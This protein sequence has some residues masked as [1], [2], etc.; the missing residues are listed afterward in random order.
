MS[1]TCSIGTEG[2]CLVSGIN[3]AE[4]LNDLFGCTWEVCVRVQS[5]AV[6]G[7]CIYFRLQ[8]ILLSTSQHEILHI[9][10]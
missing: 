8:M 5:R 3:G 2:K 1:V 10:P 4:R 6:F 7:F 9:T